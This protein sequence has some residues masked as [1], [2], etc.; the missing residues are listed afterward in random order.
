MN[1][2]RF[3]YE[4]V[5]GTR[6]KEKVHCACTDYDVTYDTDADDCVKNGKFES[7]VDETEKVVE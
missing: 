4:C 7:A 3:C 1:K 2:L 5:H 6:C